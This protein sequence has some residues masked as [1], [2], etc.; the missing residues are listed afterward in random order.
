MHRSAPD[1]GSGASSRA[2][3]AVR[4]TT[5]ALLA[6]ALSAG[7]AT[8]AQAAASDPPGTFTSQN[9]AADRTA[10]NYFYRIPALAHLGDGVLVAAWD[11]RPNSAADSPNPNSIVFRHSVDN[12]ATWSAIGTIAQGH[13]GTSTV[14]QDGYSDPS[15]IFDAETGA[16]FM[17]SVYSKDQGFWGST[18]GNSPDSRTI[19]NAAVVRSDD[20]GLTWGEP[21]LITD[22]AKPSGGTTTNG[23]YSP[24]AGDVKGM[25]ATSGEG[26]QLKYGQYAG[27]LIQQYA[28]TV[29]QPNGSTAVQA[30]SVY[31]DDHGQTWQR[32]AFVGSAMD[33]N[34]TVELS[35]GR[36]ML[37]TRD[38]AGGHFRKVAI[39]TDGG[40]TYGPV[41][42]DFELPDPTNNASITRMFP[43]AEQGSSAARKLLFTNSNNALD[44]GRNNGTARVS[45]DDGATWP[46]IRQI[47][48]GSFGYS[49]ATSIAD[50][51]YGVLWERNYTNNMQFSTFDEAWL[52]Y[53][54]APLEVPAT[55]LAT[56]GATTVPVTITNQEATA[57]SG[58]VTFTV[59]TGWTTTSATVTDLAPGASTTVDLQVT[60]AASAGGAQR[61]PATFTLADGRRSEFTETLTAPRPSVLGA[62][63]VVTDTS[64]ARDLSAK[65]YIAGDV[66]SFSIKV[67]STYDAATYVMPVSTNVST[68]FLP[69][70]CRYQD[71]AAYGSYTCTT[72]KYTLTQADIDRGTFTP[73]FA[74]TVAPRA[75][76]SSTVPVSV[77]G[78]PVVLRGDVLTATI[79]GS[80]QDAD[81]DLAANPYAAGEK[82][83]YG[84]RVDNTSPLT[85]AV[86]PTAGSFAPFLP[87]GPGNCRYT[88]LTAAAGY[89]CNTPKHTVTADEAAQGYFT[90]D[91]T[92]TLSATGQK[93]QNVTVTSDEIDLAERAPALSATTAGTFTDVDGDGTGSVGDTVTFTRTVLNSG[94]VRLD[95]VTDLGTLAAGSSGTLEDVVVTLTAADVAAGTV[96]APAFEV[97]GTNGTKTASATSTGAAVTLPTAAAFVASRVY[98]AGDEVSFAG[99]V[100]RATW[101]TQGAEPGP[102]TGSWQQIRSDA[103]GQA[104]WTPSRIFTKGDMVTHD[105]ESYTAN[106]W[107]RGQTPTA[108]AWGPW[109]KL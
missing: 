80:R 94:N 98:T 104:V 24:V 71:L 107:T 70:T 10:A 69:T 101:W 59:G 31:S 93:T 42:Q 61:V 19:M 58:T 75:S 92:W 91:T 89:D 78:A 66:V 6:A 73:E 8:V 79:T 106:W 27:R 12:G 14:K 95:D 84:F 49:T 90:A 45:C 30:Y 25:F 39:S 97:S 46:G 7:T 16:L 32:G 15:L 105:G 100:W 109:T 62:T 3:T 20:G 87:P 21:R 51:R 2:R 102:V 57:L 50:G 41:S 28:A 82:V 54:C 72:P 36:V 77:T 76:Q 18:Y 34:K 40:V 9:I 86:V 22:V 53:V 63:M 37:N 64:A 43:D 74:F 85:M 47:E 83:A 5:I 44:G 48:P 103:D 55:T 52:N 1:R 17:F 88:S 38:N 35:D 56:T 96:S 23:A 60:P 4:T 67:T 65:P 68:G 99:S 26:I 81:R 29:L 11:G 108:T 13:V 33:E